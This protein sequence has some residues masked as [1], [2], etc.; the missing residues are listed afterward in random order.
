MKPRRY[1]AVALLLVITACAGAPKRPP[2]AVSELERKEASRLIETLKE[3]NKAVAPYKAIGQLGIYS[4]RVSL[5]GRTAWV[6]APDGRFRVGVL[7]LTG[8]PFVRMIC[9]RD[10]C[11]FHF[12]DGDCLR[13]ETAGSTSL[14][15]LCGIEIKARDMVLLLGGGVRLAGYDS[16][17]AYETVS[18][19]KV[20][21][22]KKSLSGTVQTVEFSKDL[23]HILETKVFGWKGLV[24]RAEIRHHQRAG[25]R[26]MPFDLDISDANGN[27]IR[28]SVERCWTDIEPGKQTFSPELP[29]GAGCD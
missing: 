5:E 12:R 25:S 11:F 23:A 24:Y 16:A 7:G 17:K 15:P 19:R 18:G 22:L 4:T 6:A 2:G 20:L 28:V 27:R 21:L 29:E 10:K 14:E 26:I 8:Q 9:T 1:L 13:R 3:K